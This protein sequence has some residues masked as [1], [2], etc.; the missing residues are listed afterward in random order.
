MKIVTRMPRNR[1]ASRLDRVLVLAVAPLRF[2]MLPAV[3]LNGLDEITNLHSPERTIV[4]FSPV[5]GWLGRSIQELLLR[6]IVLDANLS[7]EEFIELL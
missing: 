2:H 5:A 1:D 7:V 4:L 6:A 3:T